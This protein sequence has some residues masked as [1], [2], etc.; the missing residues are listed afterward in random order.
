MGNLTPAAATVVAAL[1]SMATTLIVCLLNNR[2]QRL[3]FVAEIKERDI[4]REK[5]EAV[6]AVELKL[7]MQNVDSKLNTHNGYAER[8]SEISQ[9]IAVIKTEIKTLKEG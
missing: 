6:R 5:A 7:W 3:R 1:L 2:T 4:E 8:F 9:D